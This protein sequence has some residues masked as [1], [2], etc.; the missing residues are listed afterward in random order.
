MESKWLEALQSRIHLGTQALSMTVTTAGGVY[1]ASCPH[2]AAPSSPTV[3]F[4]DFLGIL[5]WSDETV[6]VL[7]FAF[8]YVSWHQR[9]KASTFSESA[10]CGDRSEKLSKENL[11]GIAAPLKPAWAV[12][13]QSEA[14][15]LAF[16]AVIQRQHSDP[17]P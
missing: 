16:T 3:S 1:R 9:H 12:G 6:K 10:F 8:K 13:Y 17:N 15:Q 11:H 5:P 14:C 7:L 4:E 2:R